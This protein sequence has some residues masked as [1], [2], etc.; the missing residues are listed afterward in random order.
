MTGNGQPPLEV[1]M[2]KARVSPLSLGPAAFD[3]PHLG[4]LS[5]GNWMTDDGP[6]GQ[7]CGESEVE[8]GTLARPALHHPDYSSRFV[9]AREARPRALTA[10]T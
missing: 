9:A 3:G 4:D 7:P 10:P 1:G 2:S 5:R 8:G 6:H